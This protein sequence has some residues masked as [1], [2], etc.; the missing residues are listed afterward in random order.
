MHL[1]FRINT[2]ARPPLYLSNPESLQSELV[3]H[4]SSLPDFPELP[5]TFPVP[6]RLT[7]SPPSSII[8]PH[9]LR[10][11]PRP[12]HLSSSSCRSK[13]HTSSLG[14]CLVSLKRPTSGLRDRLLHHLK[15]IYE[16]VQASPPTYTPYIATSSFLRPLLRFSLPPHIQTP[17]PISYG[18]T[19]HSELEER[20]TNY[21]AAESVG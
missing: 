2:V 20:L 15:P 21:K 14:D 7:R 5:C 18:Y 17:Y 9:R 19:H 11:L 1:L 13:R 4:P 8:V 12:L 3:A 16:R 6:N 10:R